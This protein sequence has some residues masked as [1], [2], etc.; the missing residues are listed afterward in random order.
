[1]EIVED[2]GWEM[3]VEEEEEEGEKPVEEKEEVKEA[4]GEKKVIVLIPMCIPS[5]GKTSL[6]ELMNTMK[7]SFKLWSISSDEVRN[8]V[9]NEII[10]RVKSR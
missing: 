10:K 3:G 1:M 7:P 2:K 4:P 5:T 8:K 9:M 6:L